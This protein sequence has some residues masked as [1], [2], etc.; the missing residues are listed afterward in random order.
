[1]MMFHRVDDKRIINV[2]MILAI[3]KQDDGTVVVMSDGSAIK[4]TPEQF[5]PI[6]P[7]I[8]MFMVRS[9]QIPVT[10]DGEVKH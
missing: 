10:D 2:S 4:L 6:E 3:E 5:E 1:M 9:I 8:E 7:L